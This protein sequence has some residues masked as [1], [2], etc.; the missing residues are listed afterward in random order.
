ME[1]FKEILQ[2]SEAKYL[3]LKKEMTKKEE[4][5]KKASASYIEKLE[6]EVKEIGKKLRKK[7]VREMELQL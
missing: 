6:R 1:E 5:L 3:T 2:D 7:R 4:L